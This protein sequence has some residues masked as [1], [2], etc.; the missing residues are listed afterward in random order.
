MTDVSRL[1]LQLTLSLPFLQWLWVQGTDQEASDPERDSPQAGTLAE[2][3][4]ISERLSE[5]KLIAS[6]VH[7]LS[8]KLKTIEVRPTI[9]IVTSSQSGRRMTRS[10]RERKKGCRARNSSK[11]RLAF[12]LTAV[13]PDLTVLYK[14]YNQTKLKALSISSKWTCGKWCAG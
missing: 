11:S 8:E 1:T 12:A 9:A 5:G 2:A 4:A 6:V 14:A 7:D 13:F 3:Q 10:R